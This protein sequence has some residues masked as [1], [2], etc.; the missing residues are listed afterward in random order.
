MPN[1]EFT[2][3]PEQAADEPALSRLAANAFGPGRFARTAYRIRE[4][5]PP[6]PF[7]CLTGR[8]NDELIA[9]IRFTPITIGGEN[10]ALLL[11]PL[12][13]DPRHGGKGY[14]KA[15]MGEGLKKAKAA[16]YRLVI[17]V[18]DLPYYERFGF[19]QVPVV[20]SC[21]RGRSTPTV[22]WRASLPR[23][24]FQRPEAWCSERQSPARGFRRP[25]S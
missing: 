11:G 2:I 8:L 21:S 13:V 15:L 1:T 3:T 25:S 16:G 6:V 18:G 17:L 9:G 7:L 23:A 5:V 22:S 4:G 12:V 20:R 24:H 14:G 19:V 10:S